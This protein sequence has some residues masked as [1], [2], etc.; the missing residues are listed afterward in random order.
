M[1]KFALIAMTAAAAIASPAM[2]QTVSGEIVLTGTVGAKCFVDPGA[3][4]TFSG[5]HNF[6][7]LDQANGTLRTDLAAS[8][9]TKTFTVKCTS[10]NA[11]LSIAA[12]P[13][14]TSGAAV[15]G[16]DNTIDYN[17]TLTVDLAGGGT[18]FVTDLTSSA[19]ATTKNAGGPLANAAGNVRIT[20]TGYA[21][22]NNTDL[23][24][25]GTYGNNTPAGNGVITV[26]ISPI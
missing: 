22:N 20:T 7:Q 3:G 14:A 23:L 25:A 17:A 6:G 24:V 4:P 19:G 11:A 21:T 15:A 1:K 26:T 9:G 5:S 10:G 12:T 18:E 13:M 2:A 16:Y 8:F